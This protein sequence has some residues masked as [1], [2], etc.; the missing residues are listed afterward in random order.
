MEKDKIIQSHGMTHAE[1]EDLRI[2]QMQNQVK[3]VPANNAGEAIK[4]EYFKKEYSD[5]KI[6]DH[7]KHIYHVA[8]ES[9]TFRSSGP[10]AEKLS[11]STVQKFTKEAFEFQKK[12]NAFNGQVVHILHNPELNKKHDG[13]NDIAPGKV[14]QLADMKVDDLRDRYTELT[15][16]AVPSGVKRKADLIDLI[17]SVQ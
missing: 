16:E 12:H 15:G 4:D 14:V 7:E 11:N 13:G 10:T 6:P 1:V 9:R 5:H 17:K 8:I 2:R 3:M